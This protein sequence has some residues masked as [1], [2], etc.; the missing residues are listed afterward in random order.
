MKK[1][2]LLPILGIGLLIA[3][4]L[5]LTYA[6]VQLNDQISEKKKELTKKNEEL[7]RVDSILKSKYEQLD[8]NINFIKRKNPRLASQLDS[9]NKNYPKAITFQVTPVEKRSAKEAQ[10][11]ETTG[12]NFLLAKDITNAI[13]AFKKSENAY[14]GYNLVYDIAKYLDGNKKDL[15]NPNSENWKK[16]YRKIVTDFS[17]RMPKKIKTELLEKSK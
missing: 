5:Y 13:D 16:V 2:R 10:K 17:W 6:S 4:Y 8:S 15:Q 3:G 14:N 9:I 12:F 7:E 1:N 11:W